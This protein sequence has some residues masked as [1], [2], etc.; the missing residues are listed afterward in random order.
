MVRIPEETLIV[1][2]FPKVGLE[3]VVFLNNIYLRIMLD[4]SVC[5]VS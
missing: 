1:P 2:Y 4:S 5:E 3:F